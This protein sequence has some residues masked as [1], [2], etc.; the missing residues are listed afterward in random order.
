V[1][2]PVRG[3]THAGFGERPAETDRR[4]RRHRAAG[5]L[6]QLPTF[7]ATREGTAHADPQP[8][9]GSNWCQA[10]HYRSAMLVA[11]SRV[12]YESG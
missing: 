8:E 9:V 3:D 12:V 2:S 11:S 1:E 4:Q 5:R 6:N 7:T 10:K